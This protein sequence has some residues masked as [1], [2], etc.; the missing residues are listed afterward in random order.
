MKLK[1]GLT[2]CTFAL[3]AS[4]AGI[5]FAA[6]PLVSDDAG[7]LGKGTIQGELNGDISYDKESVNGSSTKTNG[8]QLAATIGVGATDT[9]DLVFGLTRPWGSGSTDGVSFNDAG[10]TD[11]ALTMKWQVLLHEGFSIAVKPQFGY[12]YAV[13]QKDDDTLSYGAGLVLTKEF[14]QLALHLNAG[15][16]YN[17][18]N[19]ADVR[20]ACRES[21][22]NFSLAATYKVVEHM[23]LAADFG[24]STSADK[25]S[26][27]MP[28]F[29]LVG[30]IY[31]VNINLDLSAGLKVGLTKPEDDLAGTFGITLKY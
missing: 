25:S 16:V 9:L 17:D 3:L 19:R 5:C 13:G 21:I 12:S 28:V 31:G 27:E 20:A 2:V 14:E 18:Y 6:H 29:G 24:A 30:F 11:F 23:K 1:T 8:A 10:S 4:S 15:Y 26:G 22:G 7:V